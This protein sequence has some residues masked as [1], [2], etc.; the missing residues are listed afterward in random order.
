MS[1]KQIDWNGLAWVSAELLVYF[2]L[3]MA[4][5]RLVIKYLC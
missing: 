4:M 3:A 2:I 5:A 1:M